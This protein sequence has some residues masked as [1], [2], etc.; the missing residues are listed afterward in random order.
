MLTGRL[1][2]GR[3]V[4]C[5]V[6]REFKP[7]GRDF[8]CDALSDVYDLLIASQ[9]MEALQ[10]YCSTLDSLIERCPE[11]PSPDHLC[12]KFFA[13]VRYIAEITPDIDVYNRMSDSEPN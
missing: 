2:S 5:A 9:S 4:L 11:Q 6:F 13:Q 3:A 8:G 7:T 12:N 1:L 10:A